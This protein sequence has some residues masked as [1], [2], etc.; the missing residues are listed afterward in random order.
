MDKLQ[1]LLQ[2]S[3]KL[4]QH[5]TEIPSGEDRN[6]YIEQISILLEERGGFMQNLLA[7]GFKFDQANRSHQMLAELDKGIRER[8]DKVMEAVKEDMKELNNAKKNEKQYINPYSSVSTMDGRYYD[9][10]Q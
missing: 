1:H 2:I 10:K 5:L 4:Y 8:L 6:S 7:D 9:N 3:A